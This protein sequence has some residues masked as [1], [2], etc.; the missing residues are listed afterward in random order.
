MTK[1]RINKVKACLT[2]HKQNPANREGP[3]RSGRSQTFSQRGAK[4]L[5]LDVEVDLLLSEFASLIRSLT[6][7][8]KRP[9]LT[10]KGTTEPPTIELQGGRDIDSP[11][12]L[13]LLPVGFL[14]VFFIRLSCDTR[15]SSCDARQHNNPAF[16]PCS[17]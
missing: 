5:T 9:P 16:F 3:T 15:N 8:G 4:I 17:H 1:V 10:N 2:S 6:Q 13:W 11:T 7:Q 12:R 14:F